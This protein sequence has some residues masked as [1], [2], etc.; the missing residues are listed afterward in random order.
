MIR[1][2]LVAYIEPKDTN[3]AG[4]DNY[5]RDAL[6]YYLK[7]ECNCDLCEYTYHSYFTEDLVNLLRYL[8]AGILSL[9]LIK[10]DRWDDEYL[11]TINFIR[12]KI[13]KTIPVIVIRHMSA[14]NKFNKDL[15]D[16]FVFDAYHH[17]SSGITDLIKQALL[18]YQPPLNWLGP[19]SREE[20]ALLMIRLE[21][22]YRQSHCYDD[23]GMLGTPDYNHQVVAEVLRLDIYP[24]E[25]LK[26][27]LDDVIWPDF[28]DFLLE[29]NNVTIS[30]SFDEEVKRLRAM[31]EDDRSKL[32][33][34]ID[35]ASGYEGGYKTRE[36]LGNLVSGFAIDPVTLEFLITDRYGAHS[37]AKKCLSYR[38][39]DIEALRT[40]SFFDDEDCFWRLISGYLYRKVPGFK[41]PLL[42]VMMDDIKSEEH[43]ERFISFTREK[44]KFILITWNGKILE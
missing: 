15:V 38:I 30:P 24:V 36:T 14:E 23:D 43:F 3:F 2:P 26:A 9:I 22:A 11:E 27:E 16:E 10:Q 42:I 39:A 37:A 44:K 19:E 4:I 20:E 40:N 33:E 41:T 13:S 5:E 1:R 12:N 28:K 34:L 21:N 6:I 7:S 35:K 8:K 17:H 18:K 32:R 29:F 31:T 25:F